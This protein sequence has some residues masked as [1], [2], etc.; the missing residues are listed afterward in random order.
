DIFDRLFK[1]LGKTLRR[2]LILTL[3][4]IVPSSLILAY[5]LDAF[6]GNISDFVSQHSGSD[7]DSI[8]DWGPFLSSMSTML[9]TVALFM[10]GY[11]AATLGVTIV[12]CNEMTGQKISWNEALNL[13]MSVRYAR[14]LGQQILA[15]VAISAIF[16]F[17]YII[18]AASEQKAIGGLLIFAS[19]FI[20]AFLWVK[21]AFAIAAIAIEEAG[22]YQSFQRSW[23]LVKDNWWRTFGILLLLSIVIQFALSIVTTP[24][25]M[26][27]FWDFYAKYFEYLGTLGGQQASPEDVFKLFDSFGPGMGL[28]SGL[29]TVLSLLIMPLITVVMYFDLRAR[30]GEF[31][32]Q[33]PPEASEDI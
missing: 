3:I 8:E 4:I 32:E 6:F 9:V 17:P 24:L 21:W 29:S 25:S 30:K 28:V 22:V 31:T 23:A 15:I 10:L 1:L 19:F 7:F 26:L 16:M 2:N 13:T 20:V 5:G 27:A 33:T 11:I 18:L 12:A 14:L